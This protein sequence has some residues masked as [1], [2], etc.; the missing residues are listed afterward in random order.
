MKVDC[1]TEVMEEKRLEGIKKG[2]E[3]GK[4]KGK[5]EERLRIALKSIEAKIPLKRVSEILKI[6]EDELKI[7][8]E[9]YKQEKTT[10]K[11]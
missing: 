1:I 11:I 9:K 5:K 3:I 7:E 10:N 6:P 4:E 2:I 8:Y